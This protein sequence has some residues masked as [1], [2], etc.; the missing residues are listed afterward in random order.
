LKQQ[1]RMMEQKLD[2]LQK[3]T[4]ANTTTAANANTKAA[5]KVY[6]SRANA[7]YPVKGP[8][9][10][11]DAAAKMPN[12]HPTICTA[13]DQNRASG[14][15][16]CVAMLMQIGNYLDNSLRS[17]ESWTG[18]TSNLVPSRS[19]IEPRRLRQLSRRGCRDPGAG[20]FGNN[21]RDV[22][23][24]LIN[25]E[26]LFVKIRVTITGPSSRPSTAESGPSPEIQ[27]QPACEESDASDRLRH[28]GC[29]YQSAR[30]R[31]ISSSAPPEL[32]ANPA[33]LATVLWLA[34]GPGN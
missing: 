23:N 22:P 18:R 29:A 21:P 9:A 28:G 10:L 3:Q 7:I 4:A 2:R 33:A 25:L 27:H 14:H 32:A 26:K 13:D 15:P 17:V 19:L 8:A 30:K 11:S 24:D 34:P 6:V 1:L 12:N 5:A 16:K 20:C 31:R